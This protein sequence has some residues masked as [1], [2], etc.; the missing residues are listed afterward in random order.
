MAEKTA[1]VLSGLFKLN[2]VCEGSSSDFDGWDISGRSD[3]CIAFLCSVEE[4]S[5][6]E[7]DFAM[8]LLAVDV[9]VVVLS[10]GLVVGLVEFL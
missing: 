8:L 4:V 7:D 1:S 5:I 10:V 9:V 6:E 3:R 2:F